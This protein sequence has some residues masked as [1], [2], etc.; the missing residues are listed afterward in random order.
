MIPS[1]LLATDSDLLEQ[2]ET[3]WKVEKDSGKGEQQSGY[4]STP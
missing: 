4:G 2:E 3:G 1:H